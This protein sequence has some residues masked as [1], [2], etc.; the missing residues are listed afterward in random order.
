MEINYI[1]EFAVLAEVGNYMEASAT[2]FISQSALSKHIMSMEKELGVPLFERTTRR[3]VL[4]K[5]GAVFLEYAR[6]IAKLQYGYT[7]ALISAQG[8]AERSISI[9]AIPLLAPYHITDAIVQ[10]E[11]DNK[12]YSI[13]LTEGSSG[14]L[15][16]MLRRHQCE[17]AFL[18]TGGENDDEFVGIPYT[19]DSMIAVLPAGHPLAGRAS[20]QLEELA[21]E[22]FLF[23]HKASVLYNLC[24]N[25]CRSAGF[26][27]NIVYTGSR[28]EN[29]I[30]L[31]GKGMGVSL[32]MKKT[33]LSLAAPQVVLIDVL[34]ATETQIMMY[35]RKGTE[36]SAAARHFITSVQA[37][38]EKYFDGATPTRS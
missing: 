15:K 21:G 11:R 12:G 35:Y 4:N 25:A 24:T 16:E 34:P 13:H 38:K 33:T 9:G 27:P 3:V 10:F 17:L 19:K 8:V 18:R 5:Y 26:E 29:I 7:S 31:V 6:Q 28:A 37:C 20:L 36:L 30:D 32:L 2:L 14:E 1:H 23:L 22:N